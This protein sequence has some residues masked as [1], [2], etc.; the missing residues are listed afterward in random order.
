MQFEDHAGAAGVQAPIR[1]DEQIAAHAQMNVQ[2]KTAGQ[3]KKDVLGAAFNRINALAGG[4]VGDGLSCA[5][6]HGDRSN[7]ARGHMLSK[8][9]YHRFNFRKFGHWER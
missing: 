8:A 9:A 3:V 2:G 5:A 6:I 7:P 4:A 1:Y